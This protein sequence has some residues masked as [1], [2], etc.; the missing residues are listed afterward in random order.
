MLR[1]SRS[2][3]TRAMGAG[4]RSVI[5]SRPAASRRPA[6]RNG[7]FIPTCATLPRRCLEG[8]GEILLNKG[9]TSM[10]TSS[11]SPQ[12]L[13]RLILKDEVEEFLYNEAALLD[14]RRYE[15]WIDLMAADIHYFMPIR[16]NVK[17]GEWNHENYDP[18]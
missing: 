1:L 14:E 7:C 10:T 17:Y 16:K 8:R 18:A 11:I 13:E 3:G 15:E 2:S 6:T 9:K 12:A 4:Y 5:S